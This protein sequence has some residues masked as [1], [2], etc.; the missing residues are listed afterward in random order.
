MLGTF[1]FVCPN[2][3]LSFQKFLET[4]IFRFS[5]FSLFFSKVQKVKYLTHLLGN[6]RNS[7][8]FPMVNIYKFCKKEILIQPPGNPENNI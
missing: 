2:L 3:F 1:L 4:S 6:H 7:V 5:F 8:S